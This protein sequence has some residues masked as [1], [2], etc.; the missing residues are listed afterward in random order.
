MGNKTKKSKSYLLT[1][2]SIF[3]SLLIAAVIFKSFG[4]K[5]FINEINIEMRVYLKAGF[6]LDSQTPDRYFERYSLSAKEN[7]NAK[8]II[9]VFSDCILQHLLCRGS[10]DNA[11][12]QVPDDRGDRGRTGHV[13]G[14]DSKSPVQDRDL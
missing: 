3:I 4:L 2:L 12:N 5:L 1:P 9:H 8:Q 14:L 13:R 10:H 11:I 6:F 7:R